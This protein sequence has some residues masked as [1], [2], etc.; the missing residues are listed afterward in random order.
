MKKIFCCILL[1]ASIASCKKDSSG[2][3]SNKLLLSKIYLK[4]LLETEYIYNTEGKMVRNNN[5]TTG[6]GQSKLSTYRLFEYNDDGRISEI[7]HFSKEYQPTSRRIFTYSPQGRLTR[8]DEATIFTGDDNLDNMD[9]FEVYEYNPAGQLTT[10]TRR[11][12]NYTMHRRS[13]YTYDEKGNL[14]KEEDWYLDNGNMVIKQRNELD[15]WS[16]AMPE[17]WKALLL[18]PDD[19]QLYLLFIPGMKYTNWWLGSASVSNWSFVDR[20]Y[21]NQG[22]VVKET[23]QISSNGS[24]NSVEKTYEYVQ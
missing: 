7:W 16:K 22:L 12:T 8:V 23:F 3:G 24:V 14:S 9:Y 1:A 6:G 20:Q 21:N 10:L 11:H 4:G 13:D 5:Y 15:P 17:N 18:V 19:M 2:G